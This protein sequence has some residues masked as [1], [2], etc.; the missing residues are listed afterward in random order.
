MSEPRVAFVTTGLGTGGA[1]HML[2][3][4]IEAAHSSPVS[5]MVISLR[6]EG[7]FGERIRAAGVELV[8]CHLNRPH[9]LFRL[10]ASYRALKAFGPTVVQGWMYH[11]SLFASLFG[12]LLPG[13]LTVFWGMRQTLYSLPDE[14]FVLRQIIR[15]L[16]ALSHNVRGVVYNSWLSMEQHRRAGL[17]SLADL[18]I[19]N[20]FDLGRY[21]P[22]ADRRRRAR[23][24]LGFSDEQQVVGL[25]A[26]V[27]PMK[28]HAN[29]I[30]ATALLADAMP[31]ARFVLAGE[32]TDAPEMMAAL[33]QAGVAQ[34]TLCLGRIS[35]TEEVYPALD[36][37]VLA[38]AW[39]EAWPNVLGEA[40]ACGVACVATD[41]GESREIV[42]DA[43]VIVPPRDP[44]ALARACQGLLQQDHEARQALG[45]RARER[46]M[47]RFDIGAVFRQY[48]DLWRGGAASETQ[49]F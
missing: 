44:Q 49:G 30:A 24:R 16:A 41:I 40:M 42:G 23:T 12:R 13:R 39:G 9:G 10:L 28:D 11:G 6:D 29:F 22:D 27:H 3:K 48:A 17:V 19:P 1:E 4:L 35:N 45:M 38:S 46:V 2:C 32:G 26:R 14:P 25:V 7:T 31:G 37:L 47:T 34:W 36:L 8:C 5:L 43:G 21:R 18:M 33:Q 15:A 20:G